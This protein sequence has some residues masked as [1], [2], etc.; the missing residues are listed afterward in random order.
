MGVKMKSEKGP[1]YIYAQEHKLYYYCYHFGGHLENKNWK[2]K[3]SKSVWRIFLSPG[4]LEN[5]GK[6]CGGFPIWLAPYIV[7]LFDS[8]FSL[9]FWPANLSILAHK[10]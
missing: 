8:H 4:L 6:F 5:G 9:L 10:M 2:K 1:K 7:Q 3:W